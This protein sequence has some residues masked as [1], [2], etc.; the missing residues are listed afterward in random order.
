MKMGGLYEQ[1]LGPAK[2]TSSCPRAALVDLRPVE[3]CPSLSLSLCVLSCINSG[4]LAVLVLF[5][6]LLSLLFHGWKESGRLRGRRTQVGRQLRCLMDD[7]LATIPLG[8]GHYGWEN[9]TK[10]VLELL[11]TSPYCCAALLRSTC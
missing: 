8:G 6:F 7:T 11:E 1:A 9:N 5:F 4:V 10:T 3:C 2:G